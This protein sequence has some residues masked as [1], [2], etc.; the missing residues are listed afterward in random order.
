M[1]EELV[2]MWGKL[3]LTE[4]ENVD[5]TVREEVIIDVEKK[6]ELYLVEC[7]VSN[8]SINNGTFRTM[9]VVEE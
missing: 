9:M 3:S 2:D 6:G 4:E 1:E 8:K 7:I 5:I